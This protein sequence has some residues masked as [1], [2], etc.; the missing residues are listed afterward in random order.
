MIRIVY[1]FYFLF[2]VTLAA[3]D[4]VILHDLDFNPEN[5]RQAED[6]AHRLGQAR[7]V[8]VYR[9]VTAN[10]VDE[11]IFEMGERKREL[12]QRVLCDHRFSGAGGMSSKR[13]LEEDDAT[14]ISRILQKALSKVLVTTPGKSPESVMAIDGVL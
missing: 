10:S 3:A 8:T 5:D 2:S 6:R 13:P 14:A 11:S 1:C 4:T 9:L 12:S 7:D